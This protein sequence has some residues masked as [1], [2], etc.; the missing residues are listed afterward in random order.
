M[1]EN[2]KILITDTTDSGTTK[3]LLPSVKV[4]DTL[5]LVAVS[6]E[7]SAVILSLSACVYWYFKYVIVTPR[8]VYL[9]TG[10]HLRLFL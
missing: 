7:V 6:P 10:H 5:F 4:V 3:K 2:G 9:L 1:S 8:P